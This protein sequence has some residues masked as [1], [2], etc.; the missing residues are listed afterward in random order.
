MYLYI[1]I[2]IS[3]SLYIYIYIKY[4]YI[5]IYIYTYSYY[6]YNIIVLYVMS[7]YVMLYYGPCCVYKIGLTRRRTRRGVRAVASSST[8]ANAETCV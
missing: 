2:C 1:Y 4:I 3:L 7:C 6:D 5:Y 8:A